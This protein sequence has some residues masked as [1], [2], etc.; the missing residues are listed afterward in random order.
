MPSKK[1]LALVSDLMFTVKI[2]EVAKRSGLQVEYAKSD[3]EFLA[4]AQSIP[5]LAIM[6]LNITSASPVDL[7]AKLKSDDAMKAINIMCY[8]SHVQADL[9]Q[10]AQ[11]AGADIVLARSA[12][13]TNLPQILKRHSGVPM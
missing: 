13:S 6:D 2:N 12:F 11:D 7:I 10:Q 1:L 5:A 3:D 9:K 8:V 4:K